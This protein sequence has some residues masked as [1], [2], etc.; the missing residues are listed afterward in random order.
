MYKTILVPLDG[1]NESEKALAAAK[2]MLSHT[3]KGRLILLRVLE[4]PAASSW[5][6]FDVIRAHEE[7]KRFIEQY[8]EETKAKLDLP[9][10]ETIAHPGPSP[11]RA[12]AEIVESHKV[13]LIAMT[14]H[15][16]SAFHQFILGSQTEMTLRVARCSVLVVR[17]N[18]SEEKT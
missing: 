11:A 16:R 2:A 18:S 17:E 8:L 3:D 1:S 5:T 10:V 9:A 12:I 13:D 4:I 6:S 15:G 7:E 14:C